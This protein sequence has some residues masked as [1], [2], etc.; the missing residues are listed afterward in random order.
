MVMCASCTREVRLEGT[1]TATSHNDP[2][3]SGVAPV[4]AIILQLSS[5]A[6]SAARRTFFDFPL[7][8]IAINTSPACARP[9]SWRAKTCS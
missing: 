2:S 3:G 7:V 4:S 6:L 8:L 9:A 1:A 5:R